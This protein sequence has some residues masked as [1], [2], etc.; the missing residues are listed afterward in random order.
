M[1]STSNRDVL[2]SKPIAPISSW[3]ALIIG[4]LLAVALFHLFPLLKL[5]NPDIAE[6]RVL[7]SAPELP[8]NPNDWS[9]L[10]AKLDSYVMDN[11]PLRDFLI[12]GLNFF[13]YKLGYS[14][15]SRIIVG[16]HGWLFYDDGTHLSIISGSLMLD[17]TSIDYWVKGFQQRAEYLKRKGMKF[18]F[19]VAPVK[20]DIYPEHRPEWMPANRTTTEI[21]K[22]ISAAKSAGY[23]QI[24]DPRAA[25]L[26][27]KYNQKL[28]DEYDTHWTGLGAYI[29]YRQLMT[30]M[31]QDFPDMAPLPISAFKPLSPSSSEQPRDL[32]LM[33]G[34]ADFV[35]HN[36]V[37][38]AGVLTH[39]PNKTTFLSDNHS[40]VAPQILHT[41]AK[42]GKTLLLLRDSFT[43]ELL[44]FLKA[45]FDTIIM[46]HLQDGFFRK[47]L[48]EK[49]KPDAV[50]IVIIETG[51]R[52][53]MS[54][55]PELDKN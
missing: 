54:L 25:L 34:I 51:T 24:V 37:T 52:H 46:A 44:P 53:T 49:Y 35:P 30:R 11:F 21:D 20:E 13:R 48:I 42:T 6:N 55:I 7:A 4:I 1:K 40:W 12:S 36:R 38:F 47:D 31:A 9:A 45:H 50:A 2:S 19:M 18:Y 17:D 8:K 26:T 32:S 16:Q 22:I 28:Y 29:G 43:T 10:P 15:T 3:R 41:D 5:K 14:G 39:D 23:D 33:L 27:E